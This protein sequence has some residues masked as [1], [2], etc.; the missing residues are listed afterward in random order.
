MTTSSS[1]RVSVQKFG[2]FL[3]GMVMP[4]IAAFIA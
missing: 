4:N 1:L 3:S 2:S